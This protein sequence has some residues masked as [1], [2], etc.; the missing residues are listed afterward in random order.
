MNNIDMHSGSVRAV[1]DIRKRGRV[2]GNGL[3]RLCFLTELML[4]IMLS[5]HPACAQEGADHE[6]KDAETKK[7]MIPYA[8]YNDSFG[9]AVGYVYGVTGYPQ[10][11]STMLGTVIAGSNNALACYLLTREIRVPYTERLFFDTD[12]AL[13]TFGTIQSYT[14]GNPDF[15]GEQAG[16]NGSDKDNYVE[17]SGDDN[18]V[19]VNIKYLL[20]I[21]SGDHDLKVKPPTLERGLPVDGARGGE[22]WNPLQSGRTY[23]EL[24]PFW[25]EQTIDS[26]YGTH[27][28]KTYAVSFSVYRDNTEFT[29]NPSHGSAVRVRYT[30]DWGW[31]D[32]SR[33]YEMGD[34]EISKYI[35]LGTSDTFRQRV[36]A[37]DLWTAN[38][39]SWDEISMQD[40]NQV[41]NRPPAYLGATLG[42]LWRMRAYPA[43]RFND[44]AAV[45][46]ALEYRLIP[47]W[48]PFAHIDWIERYLGIEW[49]QWVAIAEV[50]RVAPVWTVG[51][52]HSDM[53]WDAGF[54]IRAMAKGIVGR[55]DIAGSREGLGVSMMV[56]QPYQF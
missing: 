33:P 43:S 3:S 15:P 5:A 10:P 24:R 36:L 8:F 27:D 28:Q 13:S 45:Y 38:A 54:G 23:L 1:R 14:D 40:G 21:G 18:L 11:Y 31:F 22:T 39:F 37:F 29:R 52:L 16:S 55:L 41:Y 12:L 46:Y 30:Q 17:G 50:G 47:E 9:A 34:V 56:G 35:S 4:L 25:R 51:E 42:G 53:K 48:N 32:S 7:L 20:P 6:A 2:F 19:R 26:D 44:Q 49:W